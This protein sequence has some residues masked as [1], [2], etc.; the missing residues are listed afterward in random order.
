[1]T[2]VDA[3]PYLSIN[4]VLDSNWKRRVESLRSRVD[5]RKEFK[6]GSSKWILGIGFLTLLGFIVVGIFFK[7]D[8]WRW[9][10]FLGLIGI[11]STII[12]GSWSLGYQLRMN[13]RQGVFAGYGELIAMCKCMGVKNCSA[14]EYIEHLY[15]A[16]QALKRIQETQKEKVDTIMG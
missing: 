14:E 10:I 11:G 3:R 1:M 15:Q 6:M 7:A 2:I 13:R 5:K 12:I 9:D 16:S 8:W 4:R